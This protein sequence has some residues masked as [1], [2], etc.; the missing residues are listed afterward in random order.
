[1]PFCRVELHFGDARAPHLSH[2]LERDV[3]DSL[4]IPRIAGSVDR[5]I[6]A[7]HVAVVIR[8][9][10]VNQAF[11]FANT[12]EEA[13]RHSAAKDC[14]EESGGVAALILLRE[15]FAPETE[16]NLLELAFLP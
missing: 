13:R 6:P 4:E 12:L 5:F 2:L 3:Q 8:R 9:D 1:M 10:A 11:L 15:S 14:I 7:V 16:M